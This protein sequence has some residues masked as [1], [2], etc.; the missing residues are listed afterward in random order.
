MGIRGAGREFND[1][2]Y[3]SSMARQGASEDAD[4]EVVQGADGQVLG[5]RG[6]EA[7]AWVCDRRE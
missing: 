6:G 2:A 5:G 7:S 1:V 3:R 4:D